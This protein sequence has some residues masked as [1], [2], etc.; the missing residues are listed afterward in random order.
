MTGRRARHV[1]AGI[2]VLVSMTFTHALAAEPP[3]GQMTWALHFTPAPTLF[4]P[5]ETPGLITPFMFLYALHDALV[6]PLPGKNMA[7]SLAESWAASA[8]G[9]VYEFVLRKGTKFHN[10]EPVTADDVKFSF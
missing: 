3:A 5:A 8:D 9:L 1:V 2:L 4:E 10:G 7:P 6:K